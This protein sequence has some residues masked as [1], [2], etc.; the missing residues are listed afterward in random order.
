MIHQK[1]RKLEVVMMIGVLLHLLHVSHPPL[2]DH[3]S[4]KLS[5]M[6]QRHC[7]LLYTTMDSFMVDQFCHRCLLRC[8]RIGL[9]LTPTGFMVYHLLHL[10]HPR[11]TS[12]FRNMNVCVVFHR[13]RQEDLTLVEMVVIIPGMIEGHPTARFVN[14]QLDLVAK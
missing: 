5:M 13:H 3:Q 7:R 14:Q 1:R 12:V 10:C 2:V 8:G 11:R 9:H 6:N 4:V